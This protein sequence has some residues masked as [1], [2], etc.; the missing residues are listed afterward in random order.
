MT[1]PNRLLNAPPTQT[2]ADSAAMHQWWLNT[3]SIQVNNMG[4]LLTGGLP[5]R[6]YVPMVATKLTSAVSIPNATDT[7]LSMNS[8]TVNNDTMWASGVPAQITIQTPGLYQVCGQVTFDPNGTGVRA[9]HILFNGQQIW[10]SIAAFS[11]VGVN[12]GDGNVIPV[13]TMPL[14]CVVGTTFYLSV[15]QS[16]GGSL[17]VNTQDSGTFFNAVRIGDSSGTAI[18]A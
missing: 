5:P 6:A 2:F 17:N 14:Q 8:A 9:A 1:S 4:L 3:F 11:Q 10:N 7:V 18:L 12:F 13:T 16:S 15:F